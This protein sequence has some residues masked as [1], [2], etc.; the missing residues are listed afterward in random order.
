MVNGSAGE[1]ETFHAE[2]GVLRFCGEDFIILQAV[3]LAGQEGSCCNGGPDDNLND[4]G[5]EADD[6][7]NGGTQLV[8]QRRDEGFGG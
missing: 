4:V 6:V 2:N 8:V 5:G 3:E 1:C 7:V